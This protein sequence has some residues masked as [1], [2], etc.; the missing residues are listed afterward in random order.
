MTQSINVFS[1]VCTHGRLVAGLQLGKE[2][3]GKAGWV[4]PTSS[5][6]TPAKQLEVLRRRL[7]ASERDRKQSLADAAAENRALQLQVQVGT[8][9]F[10][11]LTAIC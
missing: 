6:D 4:D 2:A 10:F 1:R 3:V 9:V 8:N 5:E 11:F 7:V